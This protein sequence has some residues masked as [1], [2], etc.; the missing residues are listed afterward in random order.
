MEVLVQVEGLSKA[1]GSQH[2]INHC[3]LTIQKNRLIGIIGE[4]GIGKTT[5]LKIIAG[6]C[7]YREGTIDYADI[8]ISYLF[9]RED[10]YKWMKVGDAVAYYKDFYQDF[11]E[12]RARRLLQESSLSLNDKISNLSTGNV[13]RLC[14]ILALSR[15]VDLYLF[16]EPY[17]GIDPAYKK[18]VK[19]LLLSNMKEGASVV[20]VTHLLKDMEFLFD[21]IIIMKESGVELIDA[22]WIREQNLSLEQYYL[23]ETK[24]DK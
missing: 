7:E 6:V 2:I 15:Q 18:E 5:L 11:D 23:E 1:Y 3:N 20:M 10:F 12:E 21:Q 19:R 16:D 13:E 4:N 14:M 22:D 9:N 8:S 24:H 17:G